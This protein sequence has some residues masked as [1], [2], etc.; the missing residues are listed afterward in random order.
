MAKKY[1]H[2]RN[3]YVRHSSQGKTHPE[4]ANSIEWNCQQ[5]KPLHARTHARGGNIENQLL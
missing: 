3:N 4:N 2:S 1:T 5:E